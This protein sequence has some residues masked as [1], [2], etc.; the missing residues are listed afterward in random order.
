MNHLRIFI[1]KNINK[2]ICILNKT[3]VK[4]AVINSDIREDFWDYLDW[5]SFS[6]L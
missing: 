2:F 4:D 3:I 1:N 5:S 6:Q